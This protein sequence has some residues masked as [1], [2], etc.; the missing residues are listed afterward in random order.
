MKKSEERKKEDCELLYQFMTYAMKQ[1][2]T[3]FR[4]V[5]HQFKKDND[6][7]PKEDLEFNMKIELTI[8]EKLT[9]IKALETKKLD[10]I[11]EIERVKTI[12]KNLNY[13]TRTNQK[14]V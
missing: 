14:S 1:E 9:I 7:L 3:G 13:D 6:L 8:D 5:L 2:K 4:D 10:L 12:I 11:D